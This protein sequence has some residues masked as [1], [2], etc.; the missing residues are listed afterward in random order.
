MT[1]PRR[2]PRTAAALLCLCVPGSF[3]QVPEAQAQDDLGA[4]EALAEEVTIYRDGYGVPHIYAETDASV[5]FGFL[6]AQA[7][8]DFWQVEDNFIR[9]LGRAAEV[10]GDELVNDDSLNRALRVPE[11]SRQE[12]GRLP[13]ELK[14]LCDAAAAGL[15]YFLATNT[16]V[17]SRLIRQFE[18]W[19]ILALLRWM[20]HQSDYGTYAS[21][22]GVRP[23]QDLRSGTQPAFGGKTGSNAWAVGPSRS[24]TGN[25]LLL[26]N[27]HLAFFGPEKFY[28]AH[29]HSEE[30][31]QVS[32]ATFLGFPVIHVGFT[33]WIGFAA[34][35]AYP[36]EVDFYVETFDDP[37][38]PLAYRYGDGYRLA[39][40]WT[41]TI[42]VKTD[43][44]MISRRHTFRRTHHGPVIGTWNGRPLTVKIARLE[45]GGILRQMYR[46]AL[47]RN[48]DE[49]KAAL[50]LPAYNMNWVYADRAG[51][52]FYA[53]TGAIP[54]RDDAYDWSRPVDG[55]DPST[56][57]Q[58]WHT[59][60]EMPQVTNP[61]SGFLLSTNHSPFDVS[62]TDD[63]DPSS[64]P[65]YMRNESYN[66]SQTVRARVSKEILSGDT[67]FTLDE[68]QRVAFD[69]EVRVGREEIPRLVAEWEALRETD[70]ERARRLGPAIELLE[71]WD[72]VSR[73]G[74][75]A[76]TLIALWY[77]YAHPEG[78]PEF[79]RNLQRGWLTGWSGET[80]VPR[81]DLG[82]LERVMSRLE[83]DWGTWRVP[84]GDL[85]RIQPMRDPSDL[86]D[87]RKSLG[88]AAAAPQLGQMFFVAS[89]VSPAL[90][91]RYG[92]AGHSYVSVQ[93]FG[94]RVDARSVTVFGQSAD[95]DSPHY[96]DQ[97]PLYVQ[98]EFKRAWMT[99][100]EV[101]EAAERVYRPGAR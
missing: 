77:P 85:V 78:Y 43:S 88:V 67:S 41:E 44:G 4:L 13:A 32:G 21:H 87:E 7:E 40:E 73:T 90:E 59:L 96:F 69:R 5:V 95:P 83:D 53:Y 100:A 15:N 30:G 64:F 65:A 74:S 18:G 29:L 89:I 58:G 28:E 48:L 45:E 51:D 75:E 25:A 8:D 94:E 86:S 49:F 33:P 57:W 72:G 3:L 81:T 82:I 60:A 1:R 97:G 50:R 99:R 56:E 54:E 27:P 55:S 9:A 91:R 19:H 24:A 68:L 62:V 20:R 76:M 61:A 22:H 47:A 14:A 101:E 11:L 16:D 10:Y 70:P 66:V 35:D 52:I 98:G 93:E 34:T 79:L 71:S 2:L 84:Y 92:L 36:D 46:K 12:Y 42:A 63:P 23:D 31:L 38:R 80:G 37:E 17:E 6:Y 39:E 26:S